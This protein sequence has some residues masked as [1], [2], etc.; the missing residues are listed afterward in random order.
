[1]DWPWTRG[2]VGSR[3]WRPATRKDS[4]ITPVIARCPDS[5]WAAMSSATTG[6]RWWSL[7]LLSWLASIITRSGRCAARS[8]RR[9]LAT[10]SAS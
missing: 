7:P 10:E 4:S 1:M 2:L 5:T 3:S 9:A 8:N 6:W